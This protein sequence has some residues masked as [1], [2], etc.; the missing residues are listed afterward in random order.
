MSASTV[1]PAVAA[2]H[3]GLRRE[4]PIEPVLLALYRRSS[5][6]EKLAVVTRLNATLLGLKEAQLAATRSDW[7]ASQRRIELRRWW[8]SARD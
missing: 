4:N 7:T 1:V 2:N 8:F 6:E 3:T 5:P